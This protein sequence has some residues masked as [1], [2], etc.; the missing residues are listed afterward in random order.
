M[1]PSFQERSPNIFSPK[2]LA[3][4]NQ[5]GFGFQAIFL[6]SGLCKLS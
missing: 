3:L 2:S 1:K 5:K 4:E 6:C